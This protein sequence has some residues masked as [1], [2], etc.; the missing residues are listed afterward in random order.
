MP[1]EFKEAK[2]T[3]YK[4]LTFWSNMRIAATYFSNYERAKDLDFAFAYSLADI[5]KASDGKIADK[6]LSDKGW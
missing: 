6:V 3:E 1:P 4:P 5:K 2:A